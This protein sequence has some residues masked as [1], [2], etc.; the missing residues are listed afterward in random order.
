MTSTRHEQPDFFR[1]RERRVHL[2]SY[3]AVVEHEK[4]IGKRCHLFQFRGD[5][6]DGATGI[7]HRDDLAV[8]EFDG[9]DI[10]PSRRLRNQQEDRWQLELAADD[11]LLLIA[12][13]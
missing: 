4:A 11:Q 12:A 8:D 13:G 7:A 10:D 5:Q 1:G 6:K 9:A 3:P 2:A